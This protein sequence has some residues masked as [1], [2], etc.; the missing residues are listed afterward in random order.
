MNTETKD[1]MIAQ[2]ID[3]AV[4]DLIPHG[5]GVV[6]E[7]RLRHVLNR[8]AQRAATTGAHAALLGLV[9]SEQLEH[10][11]G[12]G[13]R[14]VNAHCATLHDRWGVGRKVG[15]AWLLTAEEAES[16]RPGPSG[17]PATQE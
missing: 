9:D 6:H 13:R 16:H 3:Q 8:V 7:H 12:V 15:G 5:A 1:Q 17:R 11:W 4:T 10:I 14:R 2:D